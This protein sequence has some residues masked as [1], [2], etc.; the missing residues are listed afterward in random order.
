MRIHR[1]APRWACLAFFVI[2]LYVLLISLDVLPYAPP[3]RKRG[4]FDSPHH[5]QIG[6]LGIA[7]MGAGMHLA[8]PRAPRGWRLIFGLP[9]AGGLFAP[10]LW[11]VFASPLPAVDRVLFGIPLALGLAG[12]AL[13][14]YQGIAGR[15]FD[16]HSLDP[17]EAAR[18]LRAHGRHEQAE[19]VL[20][21]ATFEEPGR[22][23]QFQRGIDVMKRRQE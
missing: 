6:A 4:I 20:R 22:R 23:D 8:F 12:V 19:A 3:T 15:P 1:V 16:P 17:L 13:G 18:I 10:L 2:G 21:R 7:F 14:I 9:L 11:L 5:W